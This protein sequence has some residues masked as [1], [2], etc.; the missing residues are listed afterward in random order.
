MGLKGNNPV[1]TFFADS[2][3]SYK[4]YN[5]KMMAGIKNNTVNKVFPDFIP[6]LFINEKES[7]FT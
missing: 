7:P 6:R 5:Q 2:L 1:L 3:A 4:L